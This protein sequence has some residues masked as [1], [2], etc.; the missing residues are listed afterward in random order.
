MP[1]HRQGLDSLSSLWIL[2]LEC[3]HDGLGRCLG[4]SFLDQ[5]KG[6]IEEMVPVI[7][8][9]PLSVSSEHIVNGTGQYTRYESSMALFVWINRC[10]T[11]PLPH[12]V[13]YQNSM[14]WLLYGLNLAFVVAFVMVVW[15]KQC[16]LSPE[17]FEHQHYVFLKKFWILITWKRWYKF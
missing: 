10:R 13:Y 5:R 6:K 17:S 8:L 9:L 16:K 7:A 2:L 4:S 15:S 14:I 11:K 3:C 12:R 1:A